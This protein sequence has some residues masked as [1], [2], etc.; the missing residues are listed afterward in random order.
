MYVL[1]FSLMFVL[2]VDVNLIITL[3]VMFSY[4]IVSR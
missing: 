1:F 3:L 4:V 2:F